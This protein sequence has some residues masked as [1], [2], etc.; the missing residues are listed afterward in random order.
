MVKVVKSSLIGA[1]EVLEKEGRNDF[2]IWQYSFEAM[3]RSA[4]LWYVLASEWQA[5]SKL[6][7]RG[8]LLFDLTRLRHKQKTTTKVMRMICTIMSIFKP[9]ITNVSNIR[10]VKFSFCTIA[11]IHKI[12]P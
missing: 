10:L 4:I 9:G 2:N 6:V 5:R 11:A 3:R 1:L 8:F 12:I 7:Q